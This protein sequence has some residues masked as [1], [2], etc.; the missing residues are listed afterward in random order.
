MSTSSIEFSDDKSTGMSTATRLA[1][2][3]TMSLTAVAAYKAAPSVEGKFEN[4][5]ALLPTLETSPEM[6]ETVLTPIEHMEV[7]RRVLADSPNGEFDNQF[8]TQVVPS[9]W[10][11]LVLTSPKNNGTVSHITLLRP[12]DWIETQKAEVDGEVY[13]RVPECGID[14]NAR[15]H[16][17]QACP[18]IPEGNG[19]VVT[20]TFL[21]KADSGLE[22]QI[23]GES[24]PIRCTPNHPFWSEERQEFVRADELHIGE[25]LLCRNGI[26]TLIRA[27]PI[28]QQTEVFN[29]EV[30]RTHVYRV[31]ESG[32]LVHN[33]DPCPLARRVVSR[34]KESPKLVRGAEKAGKSV[35][36]SID[37]LTEELGRGNLNPGSGTKPIGKGISE[38][39]ARNGARVYF[40][41]LHDGT[42]EILGKSNKANQGVVIKEILELFGG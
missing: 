3:I 37:R 14:G 25:A 27:T 26:A 31:S 36:K 15:I 13:I 22:L 38:A 1:L 20:G 24:K 32:V 39:R 12:L 40:R 19:Q 7:G 9:H 30:H 23:S 10:R 28:D 18:V 4:T 2:V 35:Q 6:A 34:I 16:S 42:I 33:G 17:I 41:E 5:P 11:K 8:G 21:H 29:L